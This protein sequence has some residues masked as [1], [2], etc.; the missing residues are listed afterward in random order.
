MQ[1]TADALVATLS[2]NALV[3]E[4]AHVFT[5]ATPQLEL[6]IDRDK[7]EALG[8][9]P[10]MVFQTLQ[11]KL[12]SFHVNDFNLKGGVYQVKIQ[13]EP[14]RR[15]SVNDILDIT[16]S[17]PSGDEIP[18]LSVAEIAYK[19]GAREVAS[20]NKMM[21][22]Y[23]EVVPAEGVE[24]SEVMDVIRAT[25]LPEG[26]AVEWGPIQMQETENEG[27][28]KWL[29]VAAALFAYLFLVAQ[30]ESW[31]LP[32]GVMLSVT[33]A[34]AGAFFGLWA[35]GTSLSIYAQMGCVML[36]GLAAKNAILMMEFSRRAQMAGADPVEAA[37]SGADLRYRAVMM[38]AWSFIIGVLPLVFASGA[39]SWSMK[40][41]G[42]CT[43]FG[44]LAATIFGIVLVPSL[45][46]LFCPRGKLYDIDLLPPDRCAD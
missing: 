27:K 42:I 13:N 11:S 22:A 1:M 14:D 21:S 37:L 31:T 41:I 20:F 26:Y 44:M 18:L 45:Y 39:G 12:A 19:A 38:T 3:K 25:P 23:V 35:T 24:T 16:I 32:A 5:A 29:V 17:S 10:R 33:V 28:L 15:G 4:A 40:S 43:C 34:L 30:Y 6:R 7:A 9:T 2:T 8:L 46:V 36:I